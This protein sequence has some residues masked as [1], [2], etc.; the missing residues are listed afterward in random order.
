VCLYQ[1]VIIWYQEKRT[2]DTKYRIIQILYWKL[3][4]KSIKD[5]PLHLKDYMITS[6][7]TIL[8]PK[9]GEKI[10]TKDI[11]RNHHQFLNTV[12]CWLIFNL[13]KSRNVL[14][15]IKRSSLLRICLSSI[16]S[17]YIIM[18]KILQLWKRS[19]N[20]LICLHQIQEIQVLDILKPENLKNQQVHYEET[21]HIHSIKQ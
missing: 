12:K 15:W 16:W 4:Y 20:H 11:E 10:G 2:R 6:T 18:M 21:K 8:E 19:V 14:I 13:N 9:N 7:N 5:N 17:K 1:K 3:N